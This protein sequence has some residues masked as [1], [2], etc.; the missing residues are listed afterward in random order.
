LSIVYQTVT[1]QSKDQSIK[2]TTLELD[3]DLDFVTAMVVV[4]T[5]CPHFFLSI[6]IF[7]YG[8]QLIYHIKETLSALYTPVSV[9]KRGQNA[10]LKP[11]HNQPRT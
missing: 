2:F 4:G 3:L 11:G 5:R 7:I 9:D 6:H 8:G 1:K 10:M